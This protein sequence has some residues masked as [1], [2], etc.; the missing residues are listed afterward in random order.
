MNIFKSFYN[1]VSLFISINILVGSADKYAN[2]LYPYCQD[3][4]RYSKHV[5]Q[6]LVI[7]I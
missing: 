7:K 1:E 4:F 5:Y 6:N 3:A 2:F